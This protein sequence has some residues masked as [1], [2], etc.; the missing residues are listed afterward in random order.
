MADEANIP[1]KT[2]ISI[3]KILKVLN[4]HHLRA[5]Y[6]YGFQNS[7]KNYHLRKPIDYVEILLH[8][9]IA[10]PLN[11]PILRVNLDKQGCIWSSFWK[12]GR[13]CHNGLK[14]AFS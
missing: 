4:K 14:L 2:T 6:Q 9:S 5:G 3:W 12:I 10:F 1:V 13:K 11:N 8:S 7:G